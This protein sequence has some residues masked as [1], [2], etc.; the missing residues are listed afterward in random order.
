MLL[1]VDTATK[2]QYKNKIHWLFSANAKVLPNTFTKIAFN[3]GFV[4][5]QNMN[6]KSLEYFLLRKMELYAKF[7]RLS[8]MFNKYCPVSRINLTIL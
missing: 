1:I 6:K 2:N 4:K 7:V 3:H 5:S 8:L